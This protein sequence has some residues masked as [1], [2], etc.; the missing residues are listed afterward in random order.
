MHLQRGT[1]HE[2]HGTAIE[3]P[4]FSAFELSILTEEVKK[5]KQVLFA[6]QSTT[7]CN[8]RKRKTWE[9]IAE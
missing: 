8:S 4:V 1:L 5:R 3:F 9:D 6:K 7:V 2:W